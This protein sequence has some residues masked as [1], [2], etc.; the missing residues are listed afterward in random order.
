MRIILVFIEAP[1]P[2]GNAAARWYFVLLKGLVAKGHQVTAFAVTSR[3]EEADAALKL[4]PAPEYDL[5]LYPIVGSKGVLAKLRTLRRPYSYL[6]SDAMRRDLAAELEKG[7]DVLHLEHLWSGWLGLDHVRRSVLHIHYLFGIDLAGPSGAR[8]MNPLLRAITVSAERRLLRRYPNITTLSKRLASAISRIQ[9]KAQVD[10]VPLGLDAS[11]YPFDP[12]PTPARRPMVGL[13]GTFSWQPTFGA[14]ERLLTRLWPEIS[15]QVPEARLQAVGR[16]AAT[17]L[18]PF[19]DTPG[20]EIHGDVDDPIPY[21]QS[22][23]VL[24]YAPPQGSGMK[25]KIV[26][27]FALGTP[28]VT[29]A[30]GIEGLPAIDGVHAGVADDDAGLIARTVALLRDADRRHAQRINAR[31]L[32]ETVC[33]PRATVDA[34]EAVHVRVAGLPP[35]R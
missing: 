11:L 10:V 23:D 30:E 25:V 18:A 24:L 6:F 21:F 1:H 14:A 17:A 34:M 9:P 12:R 28:V 20:L 33:G 26:E 22:T 31:T 5:R 19:A 2:F 13:I 16:N 27:A 15:R 35:D 8:A 3:K 7:F 4:F 29:N 32:V